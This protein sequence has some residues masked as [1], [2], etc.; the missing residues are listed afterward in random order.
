MKVIKQVAAD[1]FPT[2][3]LSDYNNWGVGSSPEWD[4][5]GHFNF[6]VE[7]EEK[8]GIKFSVDEFADL[9]TVLDIEKCLKNK[10]YV[11]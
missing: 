2:A 6:L 1:I 8:T 10:G 9:K 7:I 4:S 3:S 5:L 11:E